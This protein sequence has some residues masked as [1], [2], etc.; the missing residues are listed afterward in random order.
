MRDPDHLEH[1]LA[2]TALPPADPRIADRLFAGL[3]PGAAPPT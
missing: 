1:D 3:E 2:L